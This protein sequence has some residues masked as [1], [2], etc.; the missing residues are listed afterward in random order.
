MKIKFEINESFSLQSKF[1]ILGYQSKTCS[2]GFFGVYGTVCTTGT[3]YNDLDLLLENE[4]LDLGMNAK[5]TS[6]THF[7]RHFELSSVRKKG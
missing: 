2:L 7:E 6:K 1:T 3:K 5:L 4:E